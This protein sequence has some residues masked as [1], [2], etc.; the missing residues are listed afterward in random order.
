MKYFYFFSFLL[1]CHNLSAYDKDY[2]KL[3]G[4]SFTVQKP[5]MYL[6]NQSWSKT[7]DPYIKANA[8]TY[9]KHNRQLEELRNPC[10]NCL[11]KKRLLTPIRVA[12][13]AP[14]TTFIVKG[15][16]RIR[17]GRRSPPIS[18]YV[19]EDSKG[20]VS[21]CTAPGFKRISM[22]SKDRLD[23]EERNAVLAAGLYEKGQIVTLTTCNAEVKKKLEWLREDFKLD[24]DIPSKDSGQSF[25]GVPCT[26]FEFKN[27][28]AYLTY[29]YFQDEWSYG[30]RGS[31]VSTI[32]EKCIENPTTENKGSV[33]CTEALK[34]ILKENDQ[35]AI[36]HILLGWQVSKYELR[37]MQSKWTFKGWSPRLQNSV[38]ENIPG[39]EVFVSMC[40]SLQ[41][42][43][44]R[45]HCYTENLNKN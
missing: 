39:W 9:H 38:I 2:P 44:Q 43:E 21:E 42:P 17:S 25:G 29:R 34:K 37:E 33:I 3:V 24:E 41:D 40:K 23:E 11:D 12:Y 15:I 16:F 1:I 30:A 6:L 22:S 26:D 31:E 27:L 20:N 28:T 14:G 10:S 45:A 7:A 32:P 18:F 13:V 36:E 35:S 4:Q 8:S 19:L 5:L